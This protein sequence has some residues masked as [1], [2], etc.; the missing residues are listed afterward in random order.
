VVPDEAHS[1]PELFPRLRA[2]ID[3]RREQRGRFLLLGSVSP[4]LMT[5]VAESLAGRLAL[6]SLI[7]LLI[8]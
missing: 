8:P 6:L 1:W 5:Q 2:A 4:A 7:P 3:A